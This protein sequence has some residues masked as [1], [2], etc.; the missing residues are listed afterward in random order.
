MDN[1][2]QQEIS[3][4][5]VLCDQLSRL[6]MIFWKF[7]GAINEYLVEFGGLL[8]HHVLQNQP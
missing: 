1:H 4:L 6:M 3:L 2:Q 7:Y 5:A 8:E